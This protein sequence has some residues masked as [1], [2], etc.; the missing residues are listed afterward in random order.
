MTTTTRRATLL[1]IAAL[2][3][4]ASSLAAHDMFLKLATYFLPPNT[5]VRALL[6]NGT[7]SKSENAVARDRFAE[8][9]LVGPGGRTALDTAALSAR[10]DTTQLRFHTAGPGTYVVGLS[11]RPREIALSGKQFND[12]LKEEGI[13]DMLAERTRSGALGEP[14]KER[15]AK[16]V[17]AILQVGAT[18]STDYGTVLGYAAE[19]VPLSN[20]YEAKRGDALRFR[21]LIEGQPAA[22]L[23]VLAGGLTP[24][25]ATIREA[26]ARTDSAGVASIRLTSAGRWYVKFIRMRHSSEPGITH[27]SQWAT[28]TFEVR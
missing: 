4:A 25:G 16:H 7:F 23:T 12:Y 22:G 19:I 26:R 14:A 20:P 27:E 15:Y 5:A 21:C 3:L 6:L 1:C 24:R 8:L 11:V 10:G 17:K 28:L 18:R 2:A 9:G 13:D